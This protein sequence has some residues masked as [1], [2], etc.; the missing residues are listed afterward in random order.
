MSISDIVFDEI[1]IFMTRLVADSGG[2]MTGGAAQVGSVGVTVRHA[3]LHQLPRLQQVGARLEDQLD[4]RQLGNRLG[5]HDVE[6]GDA[7]ERLLQRNGDQRLD[8]RRRTARGMTVWIS[9]RGG[10]NSGKTSTGMS[11]S[12]P[13]P[14]TII[15]DGEP[16]R[17]GSGTSGSIRRSS[18]S[19]PA[20]LL[21]AAGSVPRRRLVLGAAQLGRADRHDRRCPA[22]GPSARIAAIALDVGRPR[23]AART[24]TSGSGLVYVQV[25]AVGV[26]EH[27]ART[28]STVRRRAGAPALARPARSRCRAARPR[29]RVSV[30]RLSVRALD[31]LDACA[32]V[33]VARSSAA[34]R[35]AAAS[36]EASSTS[37]GQ[38][39]IR[40]RS[41]HVAC[42]VV[43]S[44]ALVRAGAA[45]GCSASG[46]RGRASRL[47]AASARSRR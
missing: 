17:R 16:R 12:W 29:P 7:V 26:V 41:L 6:P 25:V 9:T 10:A 42:S 46:V 18:A 30:T 40:S 20:T 11:R 38:R 19:W 32:G 27:R 5:A 4:R 22:A 2:I 33:V 21:G 24:K 45:A 47:A 35:G 44:T 28:G 37:D 39:A 3:L 36:D 43:S 1:P 31:R 34:A 13:T 8:L 15:A 23:S 14:K